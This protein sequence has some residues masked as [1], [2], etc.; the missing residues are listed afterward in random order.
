MAK[1][2]PEIV[3]YLEEEF[4]PLGAVD[5]AR[6]FGGWQIR[7]AGRPFA[8]VIKGTLYFRADPALRAEMAAAGS[9]PF[10]YAKTGG[11]VT[12]GRFMS[13]PEADMDDPEALLGWARKALAAD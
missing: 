13:A 3:D 9:R 11:T 8:F 6:L 1:P 10:A 2:K 7:S 12:I 4:A 5:S